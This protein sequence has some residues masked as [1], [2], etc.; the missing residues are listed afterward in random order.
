MRFVKSSHETKMRQGENNLILIDHMKYQNMLFFITQL[1]ETLSPE[2]GFSLNHCLKL[3]LMP[4][5]QFFPF[6]RSLLLYY[7]FHSKFKED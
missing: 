4:K 1:T 2:T 7:Y 5:R 6:V 3:L